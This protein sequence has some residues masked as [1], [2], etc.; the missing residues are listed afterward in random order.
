MPMAYVRPSGGLLREMC[1][2]TQVLPYFLK[3]H[4]EAIVSTSSHHDELALFRFFTQDAFCDTSN[5]IL[6]I[7]EVPLRFGHR[8]S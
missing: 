6:M 3:D 2:I 7:L 1:N 4:F 5:E 8:N